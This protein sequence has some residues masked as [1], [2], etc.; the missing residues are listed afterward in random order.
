MKL[1]EKAPSIEI[2]GAAPFGRRYVENDMAVCRYIIDDLC[3]YEAES[4]MYFCQ[5]MTEDERE[6]FS[7]G[8]LEPINQLAAMQSC[9]DEQ[10][11]VLAD[12][13]KLIN[14]FSFQLSSIKYLDEGKPIFYV[15][16]AFLQAFFW[17]EKSS[18]D[19]LCDSTYEEL[20]NLS[21]AMNRFTGAYKLVL[22]ESGG[23][24]RV[25]GF[26]DER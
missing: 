8:Q 16:S 20:I 17:M 7:P 12:R 9:F 23:V 2:A 25:E 21:P 5:R 11:A 13:N 10:L 1:F 24:M 26:K 22:D 18:F 3:V 6:F 14:H 15:Y 4:G 19:A